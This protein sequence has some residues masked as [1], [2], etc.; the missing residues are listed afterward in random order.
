MT[1]RERAVALAL[2][3]VVGAGGVV[4]WQ[5]AATPD[6]GP[7]VVERWEDGSVRYSDGTTGCLPGGLCAD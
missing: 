4:G 3:L 6:P 2:A 1:A 5:L 7:T